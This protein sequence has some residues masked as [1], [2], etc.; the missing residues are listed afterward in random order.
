MLILIGQ[1]RGA[2]RLDAARARRR[3]RRGRR[4]SRRNTCS[5]R[6]SRL[7]VMRL[8]PAC[9]SA[10]ACSAKPRAVGR[11]APDPRPRRSSASAATIST[12]SRRSSGSPPVSRSF[13]TPSC[14]NTLATR[15]I[16][17]GV[18]QSLARQELVVL[19]EQ[20]GR[21]AVGTTV[22]AAVD[23]RDAQVAQRP[24]Q[25]VLDGR[26]GLP[27]GDRLGHVR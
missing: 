19:A 9:L 15:L 20:L 3:A 13:L 7:T 17:P 25:P 16:S 6:L 4:S 5:S 14:R 18:S 27:V 24:A 22:V 2:R 26:L 21:H 1:T 8:S 12:M 11:D 10:A 23:D